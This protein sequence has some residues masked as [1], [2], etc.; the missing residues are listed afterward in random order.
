MLDKVTENARMIS[1]A[2]AA[3]VEHEFSPRGARHRMARLGGTIDAP[4]N[5]VESISR[6]RKS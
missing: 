1:D 5:A 4:S 6:S 2:R 3:K